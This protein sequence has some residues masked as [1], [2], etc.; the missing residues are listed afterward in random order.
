MSHRSYSNDIS[1][2]RY[3]ITGNLKGKNNIFSSFRQGKGLCR[4]HLPDEKLSVYY[5]LW[6]RKYTPMRT[7]YYYY[8][9]LCGDGK[10]NRA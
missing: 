4:P 6:Y 8:Y 2:L 9:Y 7:T 3:V 5:Q 10:K 1:G